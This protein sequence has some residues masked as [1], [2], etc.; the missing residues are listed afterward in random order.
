[1]SVFVH[2]IVFVH[3]TACKKHIVTASLRNRIMIVRLRGQPFSPCFGGCHGGGG[4]GVWSN[5]PVCQPLLQRQPPS[6]AVRESVCH[7]AQWYPGVTLLPLFLVPF[8]T[9]SFQF[10]HG[11]QNTTNLFLIGRNSSS[12]F[13]LR[14]AMS[15]VVV[16]DVELVFPVGILWQV[17]Y[18]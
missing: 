2:S 11:F 4:L 6:D 16:V 13:S 9:V 5:A 17:T 14:A 1:M 10:L 3:M 15:S 7:A 18:R 8:C 12:F